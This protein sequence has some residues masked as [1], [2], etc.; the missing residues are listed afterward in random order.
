MPTDLASNI[1][2]ESLLCGP[3][4][5]CQNV[6]SRLI[7]EKYIH[8]DRL[9]FGISPRVV[10]DVYLTAVRISQPRQ[11]RLQ[12]SSML[13]SCL[14]GR[15]A[16]TSRPACSATQSDVF[17]HSQTPNSPCIRTSVF[18]KGAVYALESN[19]SLNGNLQF[20]SNSAIWLGGKPLTA[21]VL[22]FHAC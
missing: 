3:Y 22:S 13:F 9:P 2:T 12:E 20:S 4:P 7:H 19:F 8:R 16:N 11:T 17:H 10:R 6:A 15:V 14:G 18:L 5:V 21:C 1:V